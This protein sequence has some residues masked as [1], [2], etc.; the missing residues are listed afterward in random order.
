MKKIFEIEWKEEFWAFDKNELK[1]LLIKYY[2]QIDKVTN[3]VDF[4]VRELPSQPKEEW[5]ECGGMPT[6]MSALGGNYPADKYVCNKCLKPIRPTP[7]KELP[8][9]IDYVVVRK[10]VKGLIIEDRR[11]INKLIDYLKETR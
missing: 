1:K 7:K 9:K 8:E 10:D 4:N 2:Q 3:L 6:P 5:C 11:I